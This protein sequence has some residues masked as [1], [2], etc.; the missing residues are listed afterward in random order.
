MNALFAWTMAQVGLTVSLPETKK[1]RKA[2][3]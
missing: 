3:A 1:A 2:A